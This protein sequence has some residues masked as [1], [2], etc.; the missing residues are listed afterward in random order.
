MVEKEIRYAAIYVL[1]IYV[2]F[3]SGMYHQECVAPNVD[4]NLSVDNSERY[5]L[6]H[7]GSGSWISGPAVYICLICP[8]ARVG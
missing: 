8:P 3:F 5:Q 7:S 1:V 2:F 4:I 6:L